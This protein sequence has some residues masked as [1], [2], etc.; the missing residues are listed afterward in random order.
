MIKN[1]LNILLLCFPESF[2]G[3]RY[4]YFQNGGAALVPLTVQSTQRMVE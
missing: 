3:R 4:Y 1:Q 2:L